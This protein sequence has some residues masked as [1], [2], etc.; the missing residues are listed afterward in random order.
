MRR[1]VRAGTSLAV[2]RSAA[3]GLASDALAASSL[4]ERMIV[5][6]TQPNDAPATRA[7][8][9]R[10]SVQAAHLQKAGSIRAASPSSVIWPRFINGKVSVSYEKEPPSPYY[11]EL[12]DKLLKGQMQSFMATWKE[13]EVRRPAARFRACVCAHRSVAGLAWRSPSQP[14]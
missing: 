2:P 11:D 1:L 8:A 12:K 5:S 4:L 13:I 3:R 14:V 9:D 6:Q 10:S 7:R